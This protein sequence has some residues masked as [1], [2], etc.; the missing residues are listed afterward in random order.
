M[1]E[2]FYFNSM[3]IY[4]HYGSISLKSQDITSTVLALNVNCCLCYENKEILLFERKINF[5]DTILCCSIL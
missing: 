4:Y 2:M 1:I 5:N 3:I